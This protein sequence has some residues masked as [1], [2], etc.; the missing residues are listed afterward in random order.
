M[1]LKAILLF[2]GI[3]AIIVISYALEYPNMTQGKSGQGFV[4]DVS[5]GTFQFYAYSGVCYLIYRFVN[6]LKKKK[7]NQKS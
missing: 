1:G 5:Y 7:T 6:G 4:Y 2:V 3:P